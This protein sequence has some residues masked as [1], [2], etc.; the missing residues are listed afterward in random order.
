MRK[1]LFGALVAM[2]TLSAQA[3]TADPV[4]MTINGK[5]VTRGEF[6]YSFRKNGSVEG[7]VEKKTVKEYV[8]MFINYKLKVEAA[9]AA[10]LDTLSSF[11][12]EFLTYRDMQL[13]PYMVD[14]TYIDSVAHVV[15]ENTLKQ[16]GGKD[17]IRPAHILIRVPQSAKDA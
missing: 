3:Q 16:T 13:T 14:S 7:A 1:F 6:E 4:V 5:Q 10:R 17:L 9:E 12:K 11:K 8:P 2:T 15:F